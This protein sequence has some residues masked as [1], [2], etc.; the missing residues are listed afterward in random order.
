MSTELAIE[1]E[2]KIRAQKKRILQLQKMKYLSGY[3]TAADTNFLASREMNKDDLFEQDRRTHLSDHK[4]AGEHNDI[5]RSLNNLAISDGQYYGKVNDFQRQSYTFGARTP[6][7]RKGIRHPVDEAGKSHGENTKQGSVTEISTIVAYEEE[8]AAQ[9][10]PSF[11][12]GSTEYH[13]KANE[14]KKKKAERRRKLDSASNQHYNPFNFAPTNEHARMAEDFP[15]RASENLQRLHSEQK[16]LRSASYP[17]KLP[18]YR[19][20]V[21]ADI[22]LLNPFAFVEKVPPI[23]DSSSGP[24]THRINFE[25]FARKQQEILEESLR[26]LEENLDNTFSRLR[27]YIKTVNIISRNEGHS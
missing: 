3:L 12:T 19:T 11:P 14:I 4:R 15:S 10:T 13:R 26:R 5:E 17:T 2:A 16:D 22:L 1:R 6:I 21:N 25:G 23:Y 8:P 27:R 7:L 20:E 24:R 18:S 9:Y